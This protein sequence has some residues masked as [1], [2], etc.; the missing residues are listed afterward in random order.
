MASAP[1]EPVGESSSASLPTAAR[2]PVMLLALWFGLAAGLLEMIL[3]MVRVL[4]FENGVFLRSPHFPWMI[5]VADLGL[6][7]AFGVAMTPPARVWPTI[8]GGLA[9]AGFVF[10]AC[11]SQLLLIRGLMLVACVVLAA[12]IARVLTPRLLRRRE[13]FLKAVRWTAPV[14]AMLLI[15]IAAASFARPA[16]RKETGQTPTTVPSAS[17][18][19]VLLIVLDTV[20]ADHLSLYGYNRDTTPNLAR[21][22]KQGVRFDR[23]HSSAPWTLPSHATIFTGRWPHEL[24]IETVGRLDSTYPTLA[25]FL[26][27][28]G[29][30]TAGV[31][32]NQ[33]FCGYETGLDRGFA[34]Y[35]DFQVTPGEVLRSSSVGWL[36]SKAFTRLQDEVSARLTS[37]KAAVFSRHHDRKPAD[38]VNREFLDW[39]GGVKG[40]PFFAFLN[41]F[42][43]HSPYFPPATFTKH[44]GVVPKSRAEANLVRDWW[45][46]RTKPH[47]AEEIR[48]M[49]DSYDD[50]LAAQD[51]QIGLLFDQLRQRGVLENTLVIITADHG[52][53]FGEHG[54][55][56]HGY[57]LYES[58][59]RVPLLIVAP[60]GVPK[61]QVVNDSV[62]LRDLPATVVDLLGIAG[63]SRFPGA[64]LARTWKTSA[65][66]AADN[67]API[68]ELRTLI[69]PTRDAPAGHDVTDQAT[70]LFLDKFAY[71]KRE[72]G[73]EELYNLVADP[74]QDRDLSQSPDSEPILARFR[75]ALEANPDAKPDA[76]RPKKAAK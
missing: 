70:A 57:S 27:G 18:P 74:A 21:L 62:S 39:L 30:A 58:A 6:F 54:Q 75:A 33:F 43:T 55:F 22:A 38:E 47:T 61:D 73:Q 8:G 15:G 50:C 72:D 40:R 56:I 11:L 13:S 36:A 16:L 7:L 45:M 42:D 31:V 19:N 49:V 26:G 64:S 12:G 68:S 10:L 5:P 1:R 20:R 24:K 71:L 51:E 3:L 67:A 2:M 63:P 23:A 76:G 66:T 69:E 17:L 65:E 60:S 29:Y 52:E 25:E 28:R 32:A 35:R 4:G 44:F 59:T 14:M 48:L 9:V 53:E 46:Y 37:Q 41:Y 34:T